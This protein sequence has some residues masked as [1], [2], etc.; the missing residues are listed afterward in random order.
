VTIEERLKRLEARVERDYQHLERVM[1]TQ[2]EIVQK[3]FDQVN[4]ALLEQQMALKAHSDGVKEALSEVVQLV[5]G[6]VAE[7]DHIKERL[8]KLENPPAA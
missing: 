6:T 2:R 1:S 4:L 8:D 5:S 7:I 3:A